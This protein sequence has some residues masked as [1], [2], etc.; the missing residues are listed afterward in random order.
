MIASSRQLEPAFPREVVEVWHPVLSTHIFFINDPS[1]ARCVQ[2]RER[3]F[4]HMVLFQ[5][6]LG[7]NMKTVPGPGF[8]AP[9]RVK[10]SANMR[11]EN[12]FPFAVLSFGIHAG[13]VGQ[14]GSPLSL[15]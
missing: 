7:K 3:P 14:H 12:S 5:E 9:Q 10:M 2:Y 8:T 6:D 13:K 4:G 1:H 15:S 11:I